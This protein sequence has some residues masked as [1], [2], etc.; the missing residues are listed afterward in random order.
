MNLRE[1]MTSLERDM[2]VTGHCVDSVSDVQTEETAEGWIGLLFKYSTQ[3]F[4]KKYPNIQFFRRVKSEVIKY[5][6][7]VDN[8][9]ALDNPHRA[10]IVGSS[11]VHIFATS[12]H[13]CQVMVYAG[14]ECSIHAKDDS[15]VYI[16]CANRSDVTI[17]QKSSRAKVI[18]MH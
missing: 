13:V 17:I 10:V 6:V 5:N 1:E 8:S 2:I 16:Y 4:E 15:V 12:Y 7:I 18:W 9:F 11:N 3:L 14:A